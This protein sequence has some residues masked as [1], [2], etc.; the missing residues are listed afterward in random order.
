MT[1]DDFIK[2]IANIAVKDWNDRQIMLPSV[3]IA[4]AILE[5]AWGK[6]EMAIN[7]NAL[8]GIKAN[9]W[10]GATYI[11]E[12]TEQRPDGSYYTVND[13]KWRAYKSWEESIIDHNT[14]IATREIS[15][16]VLRYQDIIGNDEY[17]L[18]CQLLKDCGYATS[19]TYPDKLIN[20]IEKYNL[21]RYDRSNVMKI[22]VHAGHNPDGKVACG[23]VGL[24]K[25]S[26]EARLVKNEVIRLL[27]SLGHTVY[28][29]TVD[30]GKSQSDVLQ[31][32]V[33]KCNSN[34]VDLDISIHF[35]SGRNDS[36]GDSKT[37]GVEVYIYDS[38]S[39]A[40]PYAENVCKA[41][42]ALGFNNRCV[43]YSTSLY[44]LKKTKAPAMLIECCFVDDA[45]DV[46]LYDAEKMAK[47]IV[48]GIT[49][50]EV[51][52][53]D[54]EILYRVQCGAFKNKSNAEALRDKLKASGFEA[55]VISG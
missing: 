31:N 13:T 50:Q 47:A 44:V 36:T 53:S 19:I 12:A 27:K 14:Y 21:T 46:K 35:N 16:G 30:N 20:L 51:T 32:I 54:Q 5:S 17:I 49:G 40:K 23:A 39:A 18:V 22:N 41:V 38:K 9:G 52:E 34:T 10:T 33:K 26:T 7:A 1:N 2:Q 37:G 4:Q 3:V 6:S 15:K 25:E 24:I 28:D 43:K 8:F 55:V 29:C 11:K 42:S 48:K 45:D